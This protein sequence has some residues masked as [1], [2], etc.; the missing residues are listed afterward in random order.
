MNKVL[1]QKGK[2]IM[3]IIIKAKQIHKIK[4]RHFKIIIVYIKASLLL[5]YYH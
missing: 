1:K 2:I 5:S 3:S 4:Y